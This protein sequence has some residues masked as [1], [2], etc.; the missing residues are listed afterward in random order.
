MIS[1][2]GYNLT[3][4][5]SIPLINVIAMLLIK[6]LIKC[7]DKVILNILFKQFHLI[8]QYL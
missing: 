7:I 8:I 6:L 5:K 2:I 1:K 3:K 4:S